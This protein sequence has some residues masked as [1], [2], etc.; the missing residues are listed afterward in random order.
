MSAIVVSSHSKFTGMC[1]DNEEF[2]I[3]ADGASEVFFDCYFEDCKFTFVD[4]VCPIHH[5][6]SKCHIFN[7]KVFARLLCIY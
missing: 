5:L 4:S 1:F 7:C 6:M 2:Q 3:T